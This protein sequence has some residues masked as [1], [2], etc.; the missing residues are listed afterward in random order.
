MPWYQ[1]IRWSLV[2][3]STAMML[4]VFAEFA[5]YIYDLDRAFRISNIVSYQELKEPRADTPTVSV[6]EEKEI[7]EALGQRYYYLGKGAQ[8]YA[9]ES[10]D[11]SYV[12]KFFKHQHWRPRPWVQHI[13][14]PPFLDKRRESYLLKRKQKRKRHFRSYWLA[15]RDLRQ[16]TGLLF[17]HLRR[18]PVKV[19]EL[20]L[21]TPR[22]K[23]YQV[24]LEEMEFLLQRRAK[25]LRPALQDDKRLFR[26]DRARARIDQLVDTVCRRLRKGITDWDPAFAQNYGFVGDV[27]VQVDVGGFSEDRR[28][29]QGKKFYERVSLE[30]RGLREWL[31]QEWPELV[32]HLDMRIKRLRAG[33]IRRK[34]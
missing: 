11:G 7:T 28:F 34:V 14:L 22:G 18:Q 17:A 2:G 27:A 6:T 29:V 16:E 12:V 25:M 20:T 21:V 5:H 24:N 13:P 31:K 8:A 32:Q 26:S 9:F 4:W 10:A 23:E 1:W 33:T 19:R 15:F 3:F 30:L